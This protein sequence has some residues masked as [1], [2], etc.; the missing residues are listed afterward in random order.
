MMT[1]TAAA[2]NESTRSA[3]GIVLSKLAPPCTCRSAESAPDGVSGSGAGGDQRQRAQGQLDGSDAAL[4]GDGRPR[5]REEGPVKAVDVILAARDGGARGPAR[6]GG[7]QDA[8]ARGRGA[9]RRTEPGR[10]G[11]EVSVE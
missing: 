9:E 8:V 2:A 4:D 7:D 6:A 5:Q 10:A 11:A 3:S 1:S